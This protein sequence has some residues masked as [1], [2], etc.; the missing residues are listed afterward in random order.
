MGGKEKS[1]IQEFKNEQFQEL[2]NRINKAAGFD[3]VLEVAWDTLIEDRFSHLYHDSFPKIYFLPILEAFNTICIDKLGQEL[4]KDGLKKV[5]IINNDNY[6]NPEKAITFS[7]GVLTIDH[8]PILN[9]DKIEDRT[10]QIVTLL[11]NNLEEVSPAIRETLA[12]QEEKTV[13]ID[14]LHNQYLAL[15]YEKQCLFADMVG[16]SSWE[17]NMATGTVTFGEQ[18]FP[19]QMLA[20]YSEKEK[21]W[22]WAWGN[23]QSGIPERLLKTAI[24]LK[25]IG[26]EKDIE[27]FYTSKIDCN[28]DPGHFYGALASA[29]TNSS[30]YCQLSFKGL[31][32]YVLIK[33]EVLDTKALQD[34]SLIISNFT[35][36]IATIECSHKHA[37]Y[38]YLQQKGFDVRLTDN[39]VFAVKGEDQILGIFDL[40]G[41][42]VKIS[43][44]LMT[45]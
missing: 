40:K 26:N 24:E 19:V 30:C 37:L 43:N 33:T 42:L 16:E 1:A 41:R 8:S 3:V 11:E 10:K 5:T 34:T 29:L 13:S 7:N 27:D 32:V 15:S 25:D 22:L 17:F 2:K 28:E 45:V 38:H 18:E 6:H 44:S 23:K 14:E 35:K 12:S 4:L 36:M 39:N 21:S 31:K 9:A 20:T